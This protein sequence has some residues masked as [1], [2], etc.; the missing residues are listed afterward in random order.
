MSLACRARGF[1]AT[2]Q[3]SYINSAQIFTGTDVQSDGKHAPVIRETIMVGMHPAGSCAMGLD[4]AVLP[5]ESQLA[6]HGIECLR[7]AD[8]SVMPPI[9]VGNTAAPAGM[10]GKQLSGMTKTCSPETV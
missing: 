1:R 6:L 4:F 7:I 10:I 2:L 3:L 8:T 9:V 5:V